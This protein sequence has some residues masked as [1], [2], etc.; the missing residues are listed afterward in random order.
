MGEI[1]ART[2]ESETVAGHR[3]VA[4]S[5]ASRTARAL[6][7]SAYAESHGRGQSDRGVRSMTLA[8]AQSH[9]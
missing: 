2:R 6:T 1:T 7:Q 3:R 5:R 9:E 4:C 8:P